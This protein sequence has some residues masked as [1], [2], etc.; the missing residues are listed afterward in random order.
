MTNTKY[1][2]HFGQLSELSQAAETP[3]I[4]EHWKLVLRL[5]LYL[6]CCLPVTWLFGLLL[7]LR[8]AT[9]RLKNVNS[10]SVVLWS[11][12]V[13]VRSLRLPDEKEEHVR[14][15]CKI[16]RIRIICEAP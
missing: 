10:S 3:R 1:G 8:S 2:K 15:S 4:S 7:F 14:Q 13:G 9:E 16:G 12:R 11:H 6:D 5:K